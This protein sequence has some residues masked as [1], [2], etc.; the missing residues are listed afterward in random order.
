MKDVGDHRNDKK[1]Y[2][3][4]SSLV[5]LA[6]QKN[7]LK[8]KKKKAEKV[9]VSLAEFTGFLFENPHCRTSTWLQLDTGHQA[10]AVLWFQAD[11][12]QDCRVTG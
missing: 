11:L 8:K 10:K 3:C 2:S 1:T 4:K 6:N 5:G 7:K 9:H 12:Q